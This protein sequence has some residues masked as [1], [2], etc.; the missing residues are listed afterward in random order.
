MESVFLKSW[1][2]GDK[3]I[4]HKLVTQLFIQSSY[5]LDNVNAMVNL[6]QIYP[7]GSNLCRN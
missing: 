7:Y 2:K 6:K 1:C 5:W 3:T 4:S